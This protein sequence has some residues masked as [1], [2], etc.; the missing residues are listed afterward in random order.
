MKL[1]GKFFATLDVKRDDAEYP[2]G[3][4]AMNTQPQPTHPQSSFHQRAL[5]ILSDRRAAQATKKAAKLQNWAWRCAAN[6]PDEEFD[7]FLQT[8]GY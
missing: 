6:V 1:G 4:K 5:Q 2:I 7:E 8:Q 3:A